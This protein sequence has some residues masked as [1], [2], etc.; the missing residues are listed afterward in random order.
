M[1]LLSHPRTKL[2]SVRFLRLR[3]VAV[4]LM[5]HFLLRHVRRFFSSRTHSMSTSSS[6]FCQCGSSSPS[7]L[8]RRWCPIHL[9]SLLRPLCAIWQLCSAPRAFQILPTEQTVFPTTQSLWICK[10]SSVCPSI[11][12]KRKL[13]F[14][15]S[16]LECL[17][18]RTMMSHQ[19]KASHVT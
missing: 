8:S 11:P 6:R 12:A 16:L 3:T 5:R 15:S 19:T 9:P 18:K 7:F 4:P 2:S 10:P 13:F 17:K 14:R 1:A